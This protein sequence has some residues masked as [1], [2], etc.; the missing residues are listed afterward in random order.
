MDANR[1]HS[2]QRPRDLTKLKNYE[3]SL[4]FITGGIEE[5]ARLFAFT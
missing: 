3:I 5:K 4:L 1:F 2:E